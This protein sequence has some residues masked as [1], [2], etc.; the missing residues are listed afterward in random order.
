[1]ADSVAKPRY[2]SKQIDNVTH[3]ESII[4]YPLESIQPYC[5]RENV[6]V[7]FAFRPPFSY[8]LFAHEVHVNRVIQ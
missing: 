8:N 6:F 3:G 2:V 1:M 4:A 7:V 5:F